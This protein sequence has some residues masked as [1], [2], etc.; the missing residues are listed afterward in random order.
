MATWPGLVVTLLIYLL[1]SIYGY[2]KFIIL[3]DLGD[4]HHEKTS[5]K[6]ADVNGPL[7]IEDVPFDI[8]FQLQRLDPGTGQYTTLTDEDI[9]GYLELETKLWTQREGDGS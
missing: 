6:R 1:L 8:A 5:S 4:T 2:K 9:K 3:W 7:T